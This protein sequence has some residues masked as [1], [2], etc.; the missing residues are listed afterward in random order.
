MIRGPNA[1]IL[2]EQHA[3]YAA[4]AL[5]L[6]NNRS[7]TAKEIY[8]II[9]RSFPRA[10]QH[11][12]IVPMSLG[13]MLSAHENSDVFNIIRRRLGLPKLYALRQEVYDTLTATIISETAKHLH[14]QDRPTSKEAGIMFLYRRQV[15]YRPQ[16][17]MSSVFRQVR[18]TLKDAATH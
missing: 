5:V 8:L 2:L 6:D 12:H 1:T 11:Q 18:E 16:L 3:Y 14:R 13:Q 15:A 4:F 10:P 9:D 7:K 17:T